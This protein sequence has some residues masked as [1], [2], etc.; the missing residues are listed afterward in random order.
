MKPSQI[1]EDL[2]V[3]C[4]S[5]TVSLD[6]KVG[7]SSET[8][9]GE[10]LSDG[11]ISSN[12]HSTQEQLREDLSNVLASLK[13]MQRQVLIL[14]FGL[15]DN[16]ARTLVQVAQMLHVSEKRVSQIQARAMDIVR[17]QQPGISEYLSE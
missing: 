17:C 14:R 9:L 15:L 4:G 10:L 1:Q 8:E 7:D 2:R 6:L 16:Q 5:E 3:A 12:K 13:P 11:G